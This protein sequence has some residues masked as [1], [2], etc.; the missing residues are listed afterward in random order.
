MQLKSMYD[1]YLGSAINLGKFIAV[2]SKDLTPNSVSLKLEMRPLSHCWHC[3]DISLKTAQ[4]PTYLIILII[5]SFLC[6]FV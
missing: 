3:L 1:L 5:L 4:P 6:R 2:K